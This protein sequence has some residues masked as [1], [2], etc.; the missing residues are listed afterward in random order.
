MANVI[1]RQHPSLF[2]KAVASIQDGL[3]ENIAWLTN[4][5]P[6][7]ER[8][9]KNINGR[10]YYTPNVF[11]KGKEYELIAPDSTL[12]NFCYFVLDEPQ[13][14]EWVVG[15]TSKLECPF[16][17]VFWGDIR[18]INDDRDTEAVKAEILR[19]LT[20]GFWMHEGSYTINR[21]WQ[22]AENVFR[23]FSLDEIDNQFM[24]QPYFAFR[25]EGTIKI[26]DECI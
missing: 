9:A 15:D 18:R 19:V 5:F 8:L 2:D 16:S 4:V 12:G 13:D 24:M 3:A 25:F 7:V 26:K 11:V 17:I 1:K 6:I 14:V 20:G 10:T 21:I 22:R 23:G